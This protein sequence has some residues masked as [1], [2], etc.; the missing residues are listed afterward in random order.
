MKGSILG[1]IL[2]VLYLFFSIFFIFISATCEGLC[3][4]GVLI[5]AFP[6][7]NLADVIDLPYFKED[8]IVFLFIGVILNMILAY[9]LGA[10]LGRLYKKMQEILIHL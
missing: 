9:F 2:A 4:L 1:N 8:A 10:G 7:I 3:G 6:W 5:P